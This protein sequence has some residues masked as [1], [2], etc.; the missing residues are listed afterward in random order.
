MVSLGIMHARGVFMHIYSSIKLF[1]E[2][3]RR[4]VRVD[5][6]VTHRP[7]TPTPGEYMGE[8]RRY[9]RGRSFRDRDRGYRRRSR[10]RSPYYSRRRYRSRSRSI[11]RTRS[12]SRS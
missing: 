3:D 7:H 11:S 10:S 4:K 2:I 1:Q 6:S 12:R 8:K 9:G 5:Y